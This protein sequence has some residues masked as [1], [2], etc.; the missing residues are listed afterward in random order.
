MPRPLSS[1]YTDRR[2]LWLTIRPGPVQAGMTHLS[3]QYIVGL[4][5]WYEGPDLHCNCTVALATIVA[6]VKLL[7]TGIGDRYGKDAA[8]VT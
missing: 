8:I 4:G 7:N 1:F 6:L 5:Y 2:K 3:N